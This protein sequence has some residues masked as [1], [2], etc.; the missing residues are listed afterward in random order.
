MLCGRVIEPKKSPSFLLPSENNGY[1]E[2]RVRDEFDV[3]ARSDVFM[4]RARAERR[5]AGKRHKARTEADTDSG[6]SPAG[7]A[8][9]FV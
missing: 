9:I 2:G 1:I 3:W 7:S 4:P 6:W 8:G 5:P